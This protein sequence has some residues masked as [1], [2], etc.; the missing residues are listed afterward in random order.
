MNKAQKKYSFAKYITAF[1]FLTAIYILLF[2]M[3]NNREEIK[4]AFDEGYKE[5]KEAA[6]AASD[7]AETEAEDTGL[8]D[9]ILAGITSAE[10]IIDSSIAGRSRLIDIHGLFQTA[11][12][13]RVIEESK[14]HN[15]VYKMDNGQLTYA[16][17][18]YS[19]IWVADQFKLLK[20]ACDEAGSELLY[21]QWPY[22]VNKYDNQLPHGMTDWANYN[23]DK[24]LERLEKAG[25][26]TVDY[27]EVIRY[28]DKEYSSMFFN[29][30][31]H[32]TTETA[33]DAY[34]WLLQYLGENYGLEYDPMLLNRDNYVFTTLPN[35]FIGSLAN[36]SG[37]LYA[38][39]DDFTYIY[40]AFET[41]FVWEK[42]YK[43]GIKKALTRT[44]RFEES[45]LFMN[46]LED[47]DVAK[48]YRDNCYFN[49]N[50]PLA[51]IINN[52]VESGN[53]LYICDSYSKPVVS[54]LSL[55]VHHIEFVDL[56]DYASKIV[57]YIRENNFDQVI[58]AYY[59]AA[60][61]NSTAAF[62]SFGPRIIYSE[63]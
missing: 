19:V 3:Y 37:V 62:F 33:F 17:P 6:A 21:V 13:R 7:E 29:T 36:R 4:A 38:G 23:A 58:V 53:I 20:E 44:G 18:E 26:A 22:K 40:P 15:Y 57:D 54:L 11:L 27:R 49:G 51:K 31:H 1:V 43:M 59:P 39:I 61:K 2:G 42:Y 28:S 25:I 35:S 12:G 24:L 50:P 47:P 60:L 63:K 46:A 16:Y 30:D 14:S 10:S 52:N 56:R 41:D 8:S 5:A 34:L 48:A 9:W 32:W 55:G 45:V